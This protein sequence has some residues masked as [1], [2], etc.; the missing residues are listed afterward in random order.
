MI[1]WTHWHNE[2]LLVGGL[3][4]WGWLHAILAGPWRTRLAGLSVPYPRQ[5]AVRFYSALVI[6]YLAVG[7]PLD[8]VA[9]RFLLT[10]HMVQHMLLLY[11]AAPLF[12]SGIPHWMIRPVT[13]PP[14]LRRV[15][16]VFSNPIVCG[17]I[18]CTVISGWH[19]PLLYDWAL[20]ERIVHIIEHF[21]MFGAALFF[22]WPVLS[23][24]ADFPPT[25]P[26]WQMFYF[27]GVTIGMTPVFAYITFS[28]DV[29]YP[30]YEFAPRLFALSPREDQV[31][32]GSLMKLGGMAVMMT[33]FTLSFYRW[34]RDSEL[35]RSATNRPT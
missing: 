33:A 31:L 26:A 20:R 1:E 3:I 8:Q 32:A 35:R 11:V 29:L 24:S 7:S 16:S 9:E 21:M 27:V 5:H 10:A 18:F 12:L 4:F 15:W 14:A 22:W 30:T 34:Y 23:P 13:T 2:P 25:K 19:S 6:F 28:Q 17:V